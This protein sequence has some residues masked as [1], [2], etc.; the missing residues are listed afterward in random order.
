MMLGV[1]P[2]TIE[3][4]VVGSSLSAVRSIFDDVETAKRRTVQARKA[5]K[6]RL[7]S[8]SRNERLSQEFDLYGSSSP[9]QGQA[10][11]REANLSLLQAESELAETRSLKIA[12]EQRRLQIKNEIAEIV[13]ELSALKSQ[14]HKEGQQ[15]GLESKKVD[16]NR[17]SS[18]KV[19]RYFE[20]NHQPKEHALKRETSSRE[21][22]Q[23]EDLSSV[24]CPFELMGS[25]TDPDCPHM[26]L[27]R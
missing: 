27:S 1:G 16:V 13:S 10:H 15:T 9:S 18:R 23:Q 20:E 2:F 17:E 14:S 19:T 12:V 6:R 8:V 3:S 25:C 24:V 21:S 26:H 5:S 4:V 11:L 22:D 7:E